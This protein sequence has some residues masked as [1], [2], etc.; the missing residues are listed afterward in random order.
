MPKVASAYFECGLENFEGAVRRNCTP[1]FLVLRADH[2]A[3]NC[4][5]R[6]TYNDLRATTEVDVS[7]TPRRYLD[8]RRVGMSSFGP[9]LRVHTTSSVKDEIG[10]ELVADG[11]S[12]NYTFVSLQLLT[13]RLALICTVRM[14]LLGRFL[15]GGVPQ[16]LL[17]TPP[18]PH[19][20]LLYLETLS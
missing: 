6:Y 16:L 10:I 12:V 2:R 9:C 11:G 15:C 18:P 4:L 17:D 20:K 1:P 7:S 3:D 19:H 14:L 13:T 5:N 8:I